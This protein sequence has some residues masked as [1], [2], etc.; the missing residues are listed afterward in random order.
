MGPNGE[1]GQL[2]DPMQAPI[3]D[4]NPLQVVQ[5]LFQNNTLANGIGET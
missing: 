5:I 2:C 3:V 4:S 1:W